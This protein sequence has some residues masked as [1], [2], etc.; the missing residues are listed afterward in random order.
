MR[1]APR[2]LWI[3]RACERR[4]TGA[5]QAHCTCCHEH[6]STATNFDAHWRAGSET[7]TYPGLIMDK[8]GKPKFV[9]VQMRDGHTWVRRENHSNLHPWGGFKRDRQEDT[10]AGV[11]DG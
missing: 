3:C 10:A 4:W 6:F 11:S 9:R 1:Y 2:R 8:Q 7:C 5:V